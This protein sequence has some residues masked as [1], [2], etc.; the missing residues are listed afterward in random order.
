MWK[1]GRAG[2]R[3]RDLIPSRLGG[4]YIASHIHIPTGGEVP[5]YVHFHKVKF[6]TIFCYKGWVR[7]VY[8]GQGESFVMQAGDCVLQPPQIRH[9]VL[10]SSNDLQVIE[11]GSP[12][13]HQTIADLVLTLPT[14]SFPRQIESG[15]DRHSV[16]SKTRFASGFPVISGEAL[17]LLL[18]HMQMRCAPHWKQ[19]SVDI[20][21]GH[22]KTVAL[23]KQPVDWHLS[24]CTSP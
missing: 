11:I 9:R 22:T 3:Y 16:V 12:A 17:R 24:E 4:R 8:E 5:D 18:L 21:Y 2:M 19:C 23:R 1:V 10:E 20:L 6:Q 14:V 13:I 15:L 7:V